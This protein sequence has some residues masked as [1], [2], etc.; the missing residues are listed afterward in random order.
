MKPLDLNTRKHLA[1]LLTIAT[2][3]D[4]DR[5]QRA[6]AFDEAL[7]K[8]SDWLAPHPLDNAGLDPPLTDLLKE[9]QK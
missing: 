4:L 3:P 6:Q 9:A 7:E 1:Q 5:A 2:S 8:L